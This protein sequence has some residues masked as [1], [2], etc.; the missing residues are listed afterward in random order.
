M[1]E[2]VVNKQK[3]SMFKSEPQKYITW[4]TLIVKLI[5]IELVSYIINKYNNDEGFKH[6][7][8]CTA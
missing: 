8:I 1:I 2:N 4:K 5:F 6:K 3:G 7:N